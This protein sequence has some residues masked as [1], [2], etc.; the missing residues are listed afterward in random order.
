MT[1]PGAALEAH[2]VVRRYGAVVALAGV[3]LDVPPGS[4]VALIGESLELRA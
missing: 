3:S 2:G 4:C 1:G